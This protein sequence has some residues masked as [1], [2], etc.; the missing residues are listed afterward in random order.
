MFH[1]ILG[2][3]NYKAVSKSGNSSPLNG[4]DA[5]VK[6]QTLSFS[7]QYENPEVFQR[8]KI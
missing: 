2:N 8:L 3:H 4:E 5:L 6:E 1:V 7:A